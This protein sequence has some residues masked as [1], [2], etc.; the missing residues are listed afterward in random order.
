VDRAQATQRDGT[1]EVTV[2]LWPRV[3]GYTVAADW[4]PF[5]TVDWRMLV[6]RADFPFAAPAG[7]NIGAAAGTGAAKNV[8][9]VGRLRAR[10]HSGVPAAMRFEPA[11]TTAGATSTVTLDLG[12]GNR[13]AA[14]LMRRVTFELPQGVQVADPA[15]LGGSCAATVRASPGGGTISLERGSVIRPGGCSVSANVVA[16]GAGAFNAKLPAGSLLTDAGT[17]LAPATAT[18]TVGR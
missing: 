2:Y 4:R 6:E 1:A 12:T 9:E 3:G 15:S 16:P 13:S 18:L 7:L 10:L 8:H 17:N 5:G 14:I 11:T